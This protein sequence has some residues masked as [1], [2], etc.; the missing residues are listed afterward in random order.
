[1]G[2]VKKSIVQQAIQELA[3]ITDEFTQYD[4]HHLIEELLG[5]ELS[6]REKKSITL[7]ARNEVEIKEIKRDPQTKVRVYIF[8]F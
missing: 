4:L 2:A 8:V 3:E 7:M 6:P 1:M 5:R